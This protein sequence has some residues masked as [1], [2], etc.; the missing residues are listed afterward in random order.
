MQF[1]L[2]LLAITGVPL[3]LVSYFAARRMVGRRVP[4]PAQIPSQYDMGYEGISFR[5]R[6]GLLLEG[7]W[8]PARN[9]TW[10]TIIMCSGQNGSMDSDLP[11]ARMLHNGGYNVLMFNFRAHGDSEG[12]YV[13]F[14]WGERYDLL[15]AIDYLQ[16]A[17]DIEHCG[18]IGFSMGSSVALYTAAE[19][20]AIACIVADGTTGALTATMSRWMIQHGMPEALANIFTKTTLW[21]GA[22]IS[23]APF[24]EMNA[25]KWVPHI[26]NC[27]ILFIHA[28][29]DQFVETKT[30]QHIAQKA[31][32][33]TEMWI[34]P[35]AKHR[36][37]H[38]RLPTEYADRVVQWFDNHLSL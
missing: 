37:A 18:V 1:L 15:G 35:H 34:V 14:G 9:D 17:H 23:G 25:A 7:W 2:L 13:T 8:I 12:S 19:S 5:S 30:I 4:D 20:D 16:S 28:A 24:L 3:A 36:E 21:F 6:D 31:H 10:R 26:K 32:V 27:P 22:R 38:K 11:Q 29:E 33:Y